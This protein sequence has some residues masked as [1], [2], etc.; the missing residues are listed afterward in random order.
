MDSKIKFAGDFVALSFYTK[1]RKPPAISVPKYF[2]GK[3][4][5]QETNPE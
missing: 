1:T 5:L 2:A 3:R 4:L